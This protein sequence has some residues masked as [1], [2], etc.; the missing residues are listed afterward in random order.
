MKVYLVTHRNTCHGIAARI[1][2]CT[3]HQ[4]YDLPDSS[5]VPSSSPIRSL[6]SNGASN[7][8]FHSTT[9]ESELATEADS[10][11]GRDM[12]NESKTARLGLMAL[13]HSILLSIWN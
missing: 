1:Y 6:L 3:I 2:K 11:K 5:G 4:I 8:A 10:L 13:N 12:F 9:I 7:Q